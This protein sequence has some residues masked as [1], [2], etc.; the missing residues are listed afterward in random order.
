MG[1]I[2]TEHGVSAVA[3]HIKV[4]AGSCIFI[5][6]SGPTWVLKRG[7]AYTSE[8]TLGCVLSQMES[9]KLSL[10]GTD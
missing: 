10:T 8:A 7:A 6:D 9:C 5:F 2:M 3:H 1:R 4:T